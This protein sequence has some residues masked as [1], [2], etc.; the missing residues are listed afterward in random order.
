MTDV[1]ERA[2]DHAQQVQDNIQDY[3]ACSLLGA[4][5]NTN[6]IEQHIAGQTLFRMVHV[7]S[8]ICACVDV[9]VLMG[10]HRQSSYYNLHV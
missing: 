3:N 8:Y 4:F 7:K 9:D 1:S 10:L 6:D 5:L 2:R